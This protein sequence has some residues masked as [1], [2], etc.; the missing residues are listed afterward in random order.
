MGSIIGHRIDYNGVGALKGQWHIQSKNEPKYPPPP[1]LSTL[2]WLKNQNQ[3][4]R[5][6]ILETEK[7]R[8]LGKIYLSNFQDFIWRSS[9][10]IFILFGG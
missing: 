10:H 1:S 2:E 9:A 8:G 3:C 7:F 5:G 6:R 4:K